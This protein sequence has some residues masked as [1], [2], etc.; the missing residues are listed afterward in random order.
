MKRSLLTLLMLLPITS[1]AQGFNAGFVQGLWYSEENVFADETV[2]IYVA[3]RNNTGG[4]LTGTVSF[5]DN[6]RQIGRSTVSALDGRIIESWVDWTPEYGEHTIT[7]EITKLE[8]HSVGEATETIE[9]RSSLAE[10]VVFVDYDTDGD[11]IGNADDRDDDGDGISDTVEQKNGTDPLVFNEPLE[12]TEEGTET[13]SETDETTNEST[14]T[15]AAGLEQYLTPSRADY[16]LTAITNYTQEVKQNLDSY[17]ATRA[18]ARESE[19]GSE[20]LETEVNADGF[21]EITRSDSDTKPKEA[22]EGETTNGL[23][24]DLFGF[25]GSIFGGIYTGL[26]VSLSW[27]LG[28]PMLVQLLL[29]IGLLFGIYTLAK[30]FGS[31][32]A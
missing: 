9:V 13:K 27:I 11:G 32:P 6:D 28:H 21:G 5:F 7:A 26:L 10:E 22:S 17:R 18:E 25:I 23:M 4:D 16:M 20:T 2:R 30:K 24:R 1:Y 8:L 14:D 19:T 15:Q 12:E 31:R 3:I 29:L